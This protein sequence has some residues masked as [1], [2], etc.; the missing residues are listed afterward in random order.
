MGGVPG[1]RPTHTRAAKVPT[2]ATTAGVRCGEAWRSGAAAC[3]VVCGSAGQWPC[4]GLALG[5]AQL[6]PARVHVSSS[7]VVRRSHPVT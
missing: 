7:A 1:P 2:W 6:E 4:L 5:C 3:G